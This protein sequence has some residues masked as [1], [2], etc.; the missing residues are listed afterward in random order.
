VCVKLFSVSN[1]EDNSNQN[2]IKTTAKS[3]K[4]KIP[5]RAECMDRELHESRNDNHT[6]ITTNG[7]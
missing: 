6:S 1:R 5:E 3:Q 2:I 7:G 4:Q